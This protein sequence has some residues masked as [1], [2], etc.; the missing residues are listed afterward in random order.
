MAMSPRTLQ[1][2]LREHGVRFEDVLDAMRFHAA[3]AYEFNHQL[4]NY[5]ISH[6]SS[7]LAYK[8]ARYNVFSSGHASW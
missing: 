3:Q 5:R 2:Q 6:L 4:S 1:R 8:F 7:R